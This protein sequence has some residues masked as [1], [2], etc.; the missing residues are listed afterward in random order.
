MTWRT[1][2]PATG[3][4]SGSGGGLEGV[5]GTFPI[6]VESFGTD[7]NI[8]V[9][10][11]PETAGVGAIDPGLLGSIGRRYLGWSVAVDG[12]AT[13]AQYCQNANP[14]PNSAVSI[15]NST[16]YTSAVRGRWTSLAPINS[17][18]GPLYQNMAAIRGDPPLS[19]GYL[20]EMV[21]GYQALNADSRLW[22]GLSN[23]SFTT[24]DPSGMTTMAG[25][26]MDS[27]DTVWQ[28]M[29]NDATGVATKISLGANLP[30][31]TVQQ[32]VYYGAI[33]C[34]P[35]AS[36]GI[37]YMM[38]RLDDPSRIASG[39]VTA[40]LFARSTGLQYRILANTGPTT[41]VA[42]GTDVMRV[43]VST[44]L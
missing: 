13:L 25:F 4:G 36:D 29:H 18:Y 2:P 19:G 42:V 31:P 24:G 33:W 41:A 44:T 30:R 16:F 14:G 28:F 8:K 43:Q 22:A 39:N 12:S 5:T 32:D 35:A 17:T 1:L 21:W 6:V 20:V 7:R 38:K 3:S 37:Y 15:S 34:S 26:G 11:E 40:N 9:Q 23:M 10:L 27:A